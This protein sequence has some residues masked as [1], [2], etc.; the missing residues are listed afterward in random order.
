MVLEGLH[1]FILLLKFEIK[2][3]ILLQVLGYNVLI[4]LMIGYSFSI[5]WI[6]R[7]P[8]EEAELLYHVLSLGTLER[9][10]PEWMREDIMFSPT[11]C[12]IFFERVTRVINLKQWGFS[13]HGF[14][15][16]SVYPP[17]FGYGFDVHISFHFNYLDYWWETRNETWG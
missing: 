1:Y 7:A 13:F 3:S 11:M 8:G 9:L 16:S 5:S 6:S 10:A 2:F 15:F 4:V 14:K 12:P 17:P